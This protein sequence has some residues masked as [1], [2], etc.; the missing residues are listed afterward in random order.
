M[1]ERP[2]P[3]RGGNHYDAPP[4]GNCQSNNKVDHRGAAVFIGVLLYNSDFHIHMSQ[5]DIG[6]HHAIA[7]WWS[8]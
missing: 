6:G 8:D 2:Q 4:R 1:T 3:A 5:A 7:F